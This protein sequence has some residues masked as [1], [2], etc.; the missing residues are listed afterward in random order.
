M[1]P[2]TCRAVAAYDLPHIC[3]FPQHAEELFYLYPNA[4]YPLTCDQLA[5]AIALIHL[6][7]QV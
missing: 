6:C 7:S 1:K 2:F 4:S 5:T 3:Q